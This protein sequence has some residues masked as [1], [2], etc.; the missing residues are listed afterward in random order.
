MGR[1]ETEIQGVVRFGGRWCNFQ[2]PEETQ[3]PKVGSG[4]QRQPDRQL[5][6]SGQYQ[7]MHGT[8]L[9]EAVGFGGIWW[10]SLGPRVPFSV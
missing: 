9:S 6:V 2:V 1:T 7:P 4:G 3:E 5:Q 8:E 10:V